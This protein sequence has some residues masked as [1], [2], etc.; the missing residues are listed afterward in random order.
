MSANSIQPLD[1]ELSSA[2][3]PSIKVTSEPIPHAAVDAQHS[4]ELATNTSQVSALRD[5]W[6]DL[7]T[8]PN[9]DLDF[10][11]TVL[12]SHQEIVR[13]HVVVL[14]KS[15]KAKSIVLGRIEEKPLTVPLGYKRVSTRP[16]RF[17]MLIH[18]G[19]L[20]EDSEE[21]AS[22]I[23]DSI[24]QTLRNGDADIAWFHGLETNSAL[25]RVAKAAG[26]VLTKDC[27]PIQL[28]RWRGRLPGS[29]DGLLRQ[30]SANTR[31]NLKRY[32]KRLQQAFAGQL[33]V[34]S[35]R[36]SSDMSTIL[37]D[38]EEIASKTYLRGLRVGFVNNEET[39]QLM[40]LAASKGW[41]RA[42]IL[43]IAG[44]PA[45]FWNGF[46]YRRTFYTWTTGYSPEIADYRPGTFLLQKMFEEL[47]NEGAAD[48]VDFGFGDA[49]YKRDWCDHQHLQASF[50]LFAPN[51]K[52]VALNCFRTP[53]IAT[54]N[55][56]RSLLTRAG[57][58]QSLKKLW[59]ARLTK[60]TRS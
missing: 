17:L 54:S 14:R 3:A 28:Q 23:L 18:G 55:A 46:L 24:Q 5:D 60:P 2:S 19:V 10:Y 15:G 52:G 21:S 13:P 35:Y 20:G 37:A 1:V 9:G 7:P 12:Q 30:L 40:A 39:R 16:V 57:A 36:G 45:A 27:F 29:Y 4:I 38:T 49:Q 44:K 59:R 48:Q 32:S 22:M 34:R 8:D 51:L 33:E 6:Q 25:Y 31:H 41:F 42:H 50:L 26:S 47:C 11:L 53:L 43:Y 56:A 58:L